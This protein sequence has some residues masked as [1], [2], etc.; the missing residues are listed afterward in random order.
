MDQWQLLFRQVRGSGGR[1]LPELTVCLVLNLTV[2]GEDLGKTT[3]RLLLRLQ[4]YNLV[5]DYQN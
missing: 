5:W 3:E 4:I 2:D 1:G